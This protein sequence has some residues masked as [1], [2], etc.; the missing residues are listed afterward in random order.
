MKKILYAFIGFLPLIVS[1]MVTELVDIN[2][3]DLTPQDFSMKSN[4][5]W[6]DFGKTP[7]Y[8]VVGN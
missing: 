4:L 5:T 3:L 1:K 6:L 2:D 8:R 7:S